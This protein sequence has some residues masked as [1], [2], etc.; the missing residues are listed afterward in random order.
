[1]RPFVVPAASTRPPEACPDS[2]R[3][4]PATSVHGRWHD[5]FEA[6]RAASAAFRRPAPCSGCRCRRGTS[7]R[8]ARSPS[9]SPG[10]GRRQER[11]RPRWERPRRRGRRPRQARTGRT[12]VGQRHD[13]LTLGDRADGER[14]TRVTEGGEGD[15]G[16]CAGRAYGTTMHHPGGPA[17]THVISIHVAQGDRRPQ[18]VC[19]HTPPMRGVG[20]GRGR[21]G[22]CLPSPT[23][24]RQR[25]PASTGSRG[26]PPRAQPAAVRRHGGQ[27]WLKREDLQVGPLL[28]AARRLQPDRPARPRPS[29]RPAWSAPA[30]ATTRRAWPTPAGG[31]ASAGRVYL[32]RTTPRQ[33][34]DR[35]AGARRRRGRAGP[36]R[37]HLRRR[38]RG[39]GRGRRAHRA[40]RWCRPFDDRAH[41]RRPGHGRRRR[42][43][44][45]LGRA[46]DVVVV[47]V[48]GGGLLAGV[49]TWLRERHP[50]VRVV[51]VEPAGAAEHD[52][53]AAP[54]A[55]R[56]TLD[57]ID[58][59]VDG[60]AVRRVGEL[61]YPMVRDSGAELRH[62]REGAVCT[63]MLDA[64]PERRHH[65][66]ARRRAGR[67]RRCG[68][69]GARPSPG[70][71]VVCLLSGGNNDVS[72]YGEVV[73]RSLVHR[74]LK[75]YFLVEF[76]QEPGALRRFLD[77][78][79]GPDDDIT[80]FEYV[81]RNNRETGPALVG[82]E[83][84]S[85]DGLRAAVGP[86]EGEPAEDPVGG[87]GE[88][89]V[90][91]PGLSR[92][93]TRR[94]APV[95]GLRRECSM[96]A[97]LHSDRSKATMLR[98]PAPRAAV[99]TSCRRPGPRRAPPAGPVSAS[100]VAR[101][102]RNSMPVMSS[103]PAQRSQ[104][105]KYGAG[106]RRRTPGRGPGRRRRW[107]RRRRPCLAG[108]A[109]RCSRRRVEAEDQAGLA[110]DVD[111]LLEDVRHA[112]VPHRH[113]EQVAGRR[114]RSGRTCRARRRQ[115]A[116]SS[117]CGSA[118][119]NTAILRA[120]AARAERGQRAVPQVPVGRRCRP[121]GSA[122][123]TPRR[124][125]RGD[126]ERLG[127]GAAG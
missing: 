6:A 85:R 72:R 123:G 107:C 57:E 35:I 91:V 75:H 100:A 104:S 87:A 121:G 8:P 33:K 101:L 54:P 65:R 119:A 78:V 46:P 52:G 20:P 103:M 66:R 106:S 60:A 47:P 63:E 10:R 68:D 105:S 4:M 114:R 82:I 2:T 99:R 126:R 38:G 9:R 92:R 94:P 41:D 7:G 74:G 70:A 64:L 51:G 77:E 16:Q 112:G 40:R 61:T 56:S 5:G 110:D 79:L 21:I 127:R 122:R 30:P 11:R 118:P 29:G 115:A 24:A 88:H 69:D 48:G 116:A 18:S 37:R 45:Q 36:R 97:L 19:G 3:P 81:K 111:E 43:L 71:T 22:V 34:R 95:R 53:R 125:R 76:P 73:E 102:G 83:L 1:M 12:G 14:G 42:S 84:S 113:A 27:V 109:G 96:V 32:P 124:K 55:A 58:P 89:G 86:D 26:H 62:R 50:A 67:R 93:A 98:T 120:A 108:A 15:R 31:S 13:R 28:Q 90:P 59:F 23:S 44:D 39:R 17:A 117:P 80:L 49:A 25:R